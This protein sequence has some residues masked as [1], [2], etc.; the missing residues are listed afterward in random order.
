MNLGVLDGSLT[1]RDQL[2]PALETETRTRTLRIA[3]L[4]RQASIMV[5]GR[6]ID[7]VEMLFWFTAP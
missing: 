5:P 2:F 4:P 7:Q 1:I 6:E 3:S